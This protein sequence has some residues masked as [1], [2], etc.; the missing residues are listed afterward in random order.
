MAER[1]YGYNQVACLFGQKIY[2][3]SCGPNYGKKIPD[4]YNRKVFCSEEFE[5]LEKGFNRTKKD[6]GPPFYRS[7]FHVVDN[8][9]FGVKGGWTCNIIWMCVDTSTKFNKKLC[10]SIRDEIGK[11]GGPLQDFP[12]V[13]VFMQNKGSI[14]QLKAIQ[15]NLLGNFAYWMVKSHCKDFD[16][17]LKGHKH[18]C[19]CWLE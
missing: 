18:E 14:I 13:K 12:V 8:D 1:F 5:E 7:T 11:Y 15:A 19:P 9:M 16:D 3:S 2:D 6:G 17:F 4:A 10:E